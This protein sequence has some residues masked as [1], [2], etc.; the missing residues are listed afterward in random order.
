MHGVRNARQEI[1]LPGELP[2][3]ISQECHTYGSQKRCRKQRYGIRQIPRSR[4]RCAAAQ[5]Q[6]EAQQQKSEAQRGCIPQ[7]PPVAGCKRHK[8]H[9]EPGREQLRR[10]IEKHASHQDIAHYR[11][12][13]A[14][15][16]QHPLQQQHN[17][18]C[19]NVCNQECQRSLH[20]PR[21]TEFQQA[22]H[23]QRR[24]HRSRVGELQIKMKSIRCLRI[25]ARK[26]TSQMY[27]PDLRPAPVPRLPV[28]ASV[29]PPFRNV[30]ASL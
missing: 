10:K 3:L 29:W 24:D 7:V 8:K 21:R 18:P 19:Y 16:P 15:P 4:R 25:H 22:Q 5:V 28:W 6:R 11:Q 26:H 23:S 17:N 14:I 9:Q 30:V 1:L 27:W 2:V 13:P 20:L 12:A